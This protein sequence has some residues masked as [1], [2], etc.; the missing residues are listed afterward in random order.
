MSG[1]VPGVLC[2]DNKKRHRI[3]AW[4]W[5]SGRSSKEAGSRTPA[6]SLR[7][8]RVVGNGNDQRGLGT[9]NMS[10]ECTDMAGCQLEAGRLPAQLWEV[11]R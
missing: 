2:W 4:Q 5:W 10:Q 3:R 11:L 6:Y 8:F 9:E 1:A 7:Y